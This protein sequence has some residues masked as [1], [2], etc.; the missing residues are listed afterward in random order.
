[1]N[2]QDQTQRSKIPMKALSLLTVSM[3]ILGIAMALAYT[4][5]TRLADNEQALNGAFR[6][7]AYLGR[8]A[9][10]RG[11]APYISFG[12]WATEGNRKSFTDGY[13]AAYDLTMALMLE[14]NPVQN[15]NAAYRDGLY[16]GK[17]D[18]EEGRSEHIASGRWA[19]E[20]DKESFA[21]GYRQAYSTITAARL[22]KTKG[23]SQ[24]S[25]IQ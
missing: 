23:T 21:V 5:G 1:M 20:Q 6:D 3:A 11:E 15:N 4:Y 10:L 8:L 19:Q 17:R 24:A 7:G 9:A 2:Q 13:I 25:L 18:A 16:L 12:R 22:E 14:E